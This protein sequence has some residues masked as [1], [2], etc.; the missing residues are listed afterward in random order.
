MRS[1]APDHL[2]GD[3]QRSLPAGDL[4]GRNDDVRVV[5]MGGDEFQLLLVLLLAKLLRV[6]AFTLGGNVLLGLQE[7]GAEALDLLL[8]RVM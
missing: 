5:H 8:D 4:R 2:L 7:L 6:A 3:E 1:H